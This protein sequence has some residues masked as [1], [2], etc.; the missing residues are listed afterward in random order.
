MPFLSAPNQKFPFHPLPLLIGLAGTTTSSCLGLQS[1]NTL[2]LDEADDWSWLFD[3]STSSVFQILFGWRVLNSTLGL[4]Y[5]SHFSVF[6]RLFLLSNQPKALFKAFWLVLHYYPCS[7]Y[8]YCLIPVC[9]KKN[10]ARITMYNC[11]CRGLLCILWTLC[12]A[13]ISLIS[14]NTYLLSTTANV[15]TDFL[16]YSFYWDDLGFPS[17]SWEILLSQA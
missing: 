13:C 12:I 7:L 15:F 11:N 6:F 1:C 5:C 9:A 2:E 4:N 17:Y 8:S 14:C 16:Y 3:L 10:Y